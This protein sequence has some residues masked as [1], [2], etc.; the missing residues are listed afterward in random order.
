MTY[1][2]TY[3]Y[4]LACFIFLSAFYAAAQNKPFGLMTDLLKNTGTVFIGGYPSSVTPEE[5]VSAIESV[6]M[7]EILSEYPSLS[8]MVPDNGRNTRQTAY[9][10]IVSDS[11]EQAE[12]GVG[13]IWDSG[14]VNSAQS[15][16]VKYGGAP[17]IPNTLYYWRVKTITDTGGESRWS[18]RVSFKTGNRL[19]P[20]RIS[21]E[22]L[23][24]SAEN[25]V[26][27]TH[28][29][30]I[31]FF[32]FGKAAFGQLLVRLSSEN[33][34]DTVTINIGEKNVADR[35]DAAPGGTIRY[36]SHPLVLQKGT[37]LYRIK[38]RK[39][40][41]NTLD[42][43]VKMP[44][45]IGEAMPFRYAEILNYNKQLAEADVIR[46]A[47]HYPFDESAALF[48]SDNEVLNRVWD[49][50]RHT[51]KA[52]SFTG[53]YIDGDRERIP[54]EADILINQLGH[55]GVDREY[56]IGR[57]SLEYIL[58][59][60]TWPTEWILQALLIAY[61][62][63]MYTGDYRALE[64][65]YD[66]LKNR[67]LTQLTTEKGLISTTTGLQTPAF[68]KSIRFKEPIRDIVDWPG[69]ERDGFV[70]CDYN[71]V[72]NAFHYEALKI[73]EQIAAVLGKKNDAASYSAARKQVYKTFNEMFFDPS[74]KLFADGDTTRHASL[75]ANM[76]AYTFGLAPQKYVPN[77]Q[78][79]LKSKGMACSV[80]G[81][82]FLM[83]ALYEGGNG[84]HAEN[85]LTSTGERSWYN[86]LRSGSTVA[87]E[88][89]DMKYKPNLDWNH[90]WGAVPANTIA[91]YV[92]GVKPSAAGF[93][94]IEFKPHVYN[95]SFI[96]ARI[97]TIRGSISFDYR[98]IT[99][100]EYLLSVEIPANMQADVYLPVPVGKS[101]VQVFLDN[102]KIN[103]TR[104]ARG[105]KHLYV[106][107][108]GSGKYLYRVQRKK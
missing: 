89:W 13:N 3:R 102:R 14:W 62:D 91:R 95:L 87:L 48:R 34:N 5:A 18:D 68:L 6:Q 20:Y 50:C 17:L 108:L 71:S 104:N 84:E 64:K 35:V 81:A 82:Q 75:H 55:Y 12:K 67:T 94:N 79:F 86:M 25:P 31:H 47:I 16:S 51:M 2:M 37:H 73:M 9:R 105:K 29:D 92:V 32:D 53:V 49:M 70:F 85:L 74:Q 63:Y 21:G 54:Y 30:N 61:Y 27:R 58:E 97:P 23:V 60:P 4:L 38:I 99:D 44:A 8:W 11:R 36:Q 33:G 90:A 24:K 45:Y 76:F 83:E 78:T 10:I 56:S 80:Y 39:D 41:R 57:K 93:E 28:A 65:N 98:K 77:I 107:K 15:V 52:T 72:V 7:A 42:V 96:E 22:I 1:R 88:A 46:E 101:P 100:A 43:A 59:K 106:G 66:L 69:N 26:A 103:L 19:E 40:K